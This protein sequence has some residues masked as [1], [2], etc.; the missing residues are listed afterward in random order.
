MLQNFVSASLT[1]ADTMMVGMLG[2]NEMAGMSLATTPFFIAQLFVF[3]IQSGGAVLISQYWGRQDKQT[4]NR[5]MGVSTFF[6][7]GISLLFAVVVFLFPQGVMGLTTNNHDLM[8][9]AARYGRIMAFSCV[10]HA[11]DMV[12]VGAQRCAENPMFGTVILSISSICN[13]VLN[14]AL[15]FGRLGLPAM[16]IEGAALATLLSRVIEFIITMGYVLFIDKRLPIQ[17]R[18]FFC[19]GKL[20]LRDFFRY[21]LPVLI[22]E[23]LWGVGTSLMPVIYGHMAASADIVAAFSLSGNIERVITVLVFGVAN[24]STVMIGKTTGSGADANTV[25]HLSGWL[26]TMAFAAGAVSGVLLLGFTFFAMPFLFTV[27]TMTANAQRIARF[28][29]IVMS[30]IIPF[31]SYNTTSIVGVLRGGGDTRCAM[32]IEISTMYLYAVPAAFISALVL[33]MDIT[34]V[35]LFIVFEDV[36]KFILGTIRYRSRLWIHN[37]TRDQS[38]FE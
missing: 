10:F 18:F 20:I 14:Y 22:N 4:I 23:T 19:P 38:E 21:A 1:L 30:C 12:F 25:Y 16:G 24:A 3:G 27:F 28:M 34:A 31:R 35:F 5:V 26:L 9:I 6:A 8:L 15:I 36:I 2:Q 37:I 7:A 33:R 17:P 13:V 32:F 29:L 11:V